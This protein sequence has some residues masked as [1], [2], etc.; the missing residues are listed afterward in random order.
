MLGERGENVSRDH[1]SNN[2]CPSTP[3]GGD[4]V[5]LVRRLD[6]V[7]AVLP[8]A[9]EAFRHLVNDLGLPEAWPFADYGGFVS[10]GVGFGNLNVEIVQGRS[11]NHSPRPS[12]FSALAFEPVS[13]VDDDFLATLDDRGLRFTG[14]LVTSGW[15]NVDLPG[16]L[17]G[18]HTFICD[19]HIP[20][21]K[22]ASL[23]REA[24]SAN[25]G[26]AL[27]VVAV[28]EVV[29]GV[30]DVGATVAECSKLLGPTVTSKGDAWAGDEGPNLRVVSSDEVGVLNLVVDARLR[31]RVDEWQSSRT[32]HD[33][34][35]GLA[36]SFTE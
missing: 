29:I 33:P 8:R 31:D 21:A 27:G 35:D 28:I 3:S 25:Q 22:D 24:L 14:P 17:D 36:F 19:Y 6:H 26:G 16:L 23:R 30:R 4:R 9:E 20:G 5:K 13:A 12:R 11:D 32:F 34:L 1:W 2:V 15:T 18:V 10:G 7:V